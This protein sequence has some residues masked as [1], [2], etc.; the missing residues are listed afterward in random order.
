MVMTMATK[1][2]NVLARVEPEVKEEAE[3]ILNQLGIPA[4]VV[5]NMLYKQIIMTKGIPF[6]LTLHKAP[7]AVDEIAVDEMSK[8]EFDSMMAKGLAQAK[9]NESRPAS[10]VL[11]DIRNNIKEWT[12]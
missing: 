4:S 12:K 6:S 5:I 3:S 9:A 8:D 11:S 1:T 2:A 10:D 7:T